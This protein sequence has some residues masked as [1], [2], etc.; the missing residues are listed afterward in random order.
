M[1]NT[2]ITAVFT[3]KIRKTIY[4][5]LAMIRATN[6][7]SNCSSILTPSRRMT[8]FPATRT[9]LGSSLTLLICRIS[10]KSF[11]SIAFFLIIILKIRIFIQNQK[12]SHCK[13]LRVFIE[14]K[15]NNS[16]S[17][18]LKME[19]VDRSL[20]MKAMLIVKNLLRLIIMISNYN[21][22]NKKFQ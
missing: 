20:I 17:K 1:C 16:S 19:P 3:F 9:N 12:G 15:N 4:I 21:N 22:N 2:T 14:C 13:Y 11:V 10:L 7:I 5:P 8:T 18:R 6:T